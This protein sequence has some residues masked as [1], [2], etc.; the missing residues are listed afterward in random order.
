MQ[1]RIKKYESTSSSLPRIYNHE[2]V[3]RH[4]EAEA[5]HEKDPER[6]EELLK[7]A[8]DWRRTKPIWHKKTKDG[9]PVFTSKRDIDEFQART[10]GAYG[11]DK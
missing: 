9:K 10:G 3:A 8:E 11:W 4:R 5:R 7:S 2:A 6:K 1:I